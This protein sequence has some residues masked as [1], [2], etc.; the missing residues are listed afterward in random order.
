MNTRAE[1]KYSILTDSLKNIFK[2]SNMNLAR[3][4]FIS[5]FIIALSK[6]QTVGFEKT[7]TAF[8]GKATTESIFLISLEKKNR[9]FNKRLLR[10]STV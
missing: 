5:L 3:I 8:E 6:V 1:S 4:N 9:L 10:S 7:A 2:S